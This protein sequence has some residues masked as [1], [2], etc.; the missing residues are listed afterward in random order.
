MATREN[1]HIFANGVLIETRHKWNAANRAVEAKAGEL[2]KAENTTYRLTESGSRKEGFHHVEGFRVWRG[3][4]G[5]SVR[6]E[7]RKA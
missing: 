4:N 7:I 5:R 6:F 3:D 2:A 1:F